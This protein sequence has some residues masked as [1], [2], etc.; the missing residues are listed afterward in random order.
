VYWS[1]LLCGQAADPGAA[2]TPG[3]SAQI[4]S[5]WDFILKGGPVMIPI[6]LC[7]LVALTIIVERLLSLRRKNILPPALLS[8]LKGVLED[9]NKT[10]ALEYCDRHPSP[11][12]NTLA[13]GIKKLGEPVEMVRRHIEEA[14]AREVVRLRKYLRVLSV[15]ASVAPLLGLLGTIFGMITA[16]QTVAASAESLGRTEL[17]AKG[18][19]EAMITTAAGL[20]VAIPT[21]LAYHAVSAKVERLVFEMDAM[22]IDF[23]EDYASAA[24]PARAMDRAAAERF[25]A[26]EPQDGDGRAVA[27]L[28][29]V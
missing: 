3:P 22:A 16:F 26:A 13:A 12:S 28:A 24:R 4:E 15:I 9:G 5:V 6:G 21:V 14:G 18:I 19:Y 8:D 29:G 2:Q 25:P 10:K 27:A 23:V 7:S 11:L 1:L 20:L 17:L